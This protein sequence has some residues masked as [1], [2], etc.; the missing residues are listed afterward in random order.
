MRRIGV[1]VVVMGLVFATAPAVAAQAKPRQVGQPSSTITL[2]TGDQVVLQGGEPKSVRPGPGREGMRFSVQKTADHL[3][4]IP[5]D[6]ITA[7]GQGR[8][9]RRLFDLRTLQEFGYDKRATVPLIVT[10]QGANRVATTGRA[11]PSIDGYA[12]DAA[13]GEA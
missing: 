3:Y 1:G 5:A 9:D 2:V 4:V 11:L 13:K 12:Y 10:G 8:V 6:A 7:V